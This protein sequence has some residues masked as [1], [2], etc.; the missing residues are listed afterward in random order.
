TCLPAS[1]LRRP[2]PVPRWP[3]ASG[4]S[5]TRTGPSAS[6]RGSRG[7]TGLAFSLM[8]GRW[9]AE[10]THAGARYA[11]ADGGLL[12]IV[13]HGQPGRPHGRQAASPAHAGGTVPA[14]AQPAARTRA[15]APPATAD[16]DHQ[17]LAL[18]RPRTPA[19]SQREPRRTVRVTRTPREEKVTRLRTGGPAVQA[20]GAD[21]PVRA[22]ENR[23]AASWI[24]T[25]N[26]YL[27]ALGADQ[28]TSLSAIRSR[29]GVPPDRRLCRWTA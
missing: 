1:T 15:G 23:D 21:C 24:A 4:A 16:P 18:T 12:E 2:A 22:R 8:I 3:A 29:T 11:L 13:H 20:L 19:G 14:T 9:R 26:G 17:A 25:Q 27:C 6:R 7:L 5:A 28:R 10:V